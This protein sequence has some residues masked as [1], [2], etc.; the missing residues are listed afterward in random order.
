MKH[1]LS[2]AAALAVVIAVGVGAF[3]ENAEP[4]AADSSEAESAE[5]ATVYLPETEKESSPD[6]G[7]GSVAAV[8]GTAILAGG[9]MLFAT[10]KKSE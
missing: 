3:A 10:K 6:T 2:A 8:A 4:V 5:A 9:I 1:I 7:V